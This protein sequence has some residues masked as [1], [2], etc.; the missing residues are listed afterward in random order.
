MGWY[1]VS[2]VIAHLGFA[3]PS[4]TGKTTLLTRLVP[5]LRARGLRL[6]YLKHA[7]HGFDLDT[8]GKDTHRLREAGASA[9]L[10]AS[11]RRWALMQEGPPEQPLADASK[12]EGAS[13]LLASLL[14]RF[15]RERTDLVLIEGWHGASFPRI[16][17]HRPASGRELTGLDDPDLIAVASDVPDQVP[18]HLP[19]LPLDDPEHIADFIL[20]HPRIGLAAWR[21]ARGGVGANDPDVPWADASGADASGADANGAGFRD[22]GQRKEP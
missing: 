19:V 4:G 2:E 22:A 15:D 17:V 21:Q 20:S 11:S 9:V 5:L 7:H 10:I 3:A 12:A 6:G 13:S 16:A 1:S 18:G 8:P 14:S